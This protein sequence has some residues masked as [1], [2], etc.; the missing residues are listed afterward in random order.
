MKV[1]LHFRLC[2]Y[3]ALLVHFVHWHCFNTKS[4]S[5][6]FSF[7][8][9]RNSIL[10]LKTPLTSGLQARPPRNVHSFKSFTIF[11][12]DIFQTGSQSSLI[13]NLKCWVVSLHLL[14]CDCLQICNFQYNYL[15]IELWLK[16][17]ILSENVFTAKDSKVI[18]VH[19][20]EN[21]L[22]DLKSPTPIRLLNAM[23]GSVPLAIMSIVFKCWNVCMILSQEKQL[24][25]PPCSISLEPWKVRK[26]R[27]LKVSLRCNLV[28]HI[29]KKKW[30]RMYKAWLLSLQMAQ[31]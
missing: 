11:L 26:H 18:I 22:L 8:I 9:V 21:N 25:F 17:K 12:S 23:P 14:Y 3:R 7:R 2:M 29:L 15:L 10:C 28:H 16:T 27:W 20:R 1:V 4:I 31:K 5:Y 30:M 6:L 24:T 13:A 19:S